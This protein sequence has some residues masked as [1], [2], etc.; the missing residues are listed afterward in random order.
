MDKVLVFGCSHTYGDGIG[1]GQEKPWEQ[2]STNA[3][4]YHM[5]NKNEIVNYSRPGN[6]NDI[7]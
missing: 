3:W 2:Y 4:P 6:S 5:F 1:G 7:Y